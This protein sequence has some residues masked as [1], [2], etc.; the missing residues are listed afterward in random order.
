MSWR[1]TKRFFRKNPLARNLVL[2]ILLIVLAFEVGE[3]A[4][5]Q[6]IVPIVIAFFLLVLFLIV[7]Q[8]R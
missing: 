4:M 1:K 6:D 2:G 8:M 3:G 7:W 5:T